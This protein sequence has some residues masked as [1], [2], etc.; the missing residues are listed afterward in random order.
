MSEP[1]LRVFALEGIGEIAAGADLAALIAG[2]GAGRL[3]HGDIL[4]VTSKI[5]S[6]A[7]GRQVAAADREQA[8]TAETVRVVAT[9]AHPGGVTRIVENRQGLIMAAAGVDASNT[10]DGTV[11]LLPVDPDA[12]ARSL[13]AALRASTGLRLGVIVTDTAGRPW[14]EGQTDIAIGAA[15]VAV[16]DDLRGTDDASGR[17]LDV[18]VAAVADEIAGAADLVKGKTSGNPVAVVRGLGRLVAE[19]AVDGGA[20]ASGASRAPGAFLLQRPSANDMFRLGTAEAH[21]EGFTEGYAA[22]LAAAAAASAGAGA[23][24]GAAAGDAASVTE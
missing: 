22:G 8:I 10:P 2:A 23:A 1:E 6:K 13:C 21:A 5:V 12:S 14:R 16:L 9:R 20:G 24:A 17:R 3:R 4:A 18:T 11:L 19:D 15:G 7:E